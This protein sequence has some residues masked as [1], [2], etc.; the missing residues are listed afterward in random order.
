M[1]VAA[2]VAGAWARAQHRLVPAIAGML[3]VAGGLAAL[4]LL[5][6]A[7]VAWTFAPQVAIGAGLGLALATLIGASVGDAGPHDGGT[8]RARWPARL[9]GRSPRATPASSS[10]CCC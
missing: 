3:L 10:D 7:A 9:P 1:P 5:P 4:G 8:R 2:L 6:A